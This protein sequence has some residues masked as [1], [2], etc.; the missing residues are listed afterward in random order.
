MI[1]IKLIFV[2]AAVSI[3]LIYLFKNKSTFEGKYI[4]RYDGEVLW[5]NGTKNICAR[6]IFDANE[7]LDT[8]LSNQELKYPGSVFQNKYRSVPTHESCW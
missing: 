7:Q 2:T 8:W 5:R 1:N 6:D 3:G 4:Y